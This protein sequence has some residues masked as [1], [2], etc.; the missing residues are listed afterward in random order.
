MCPLSVVGLSAALAVAVRAR[1]AEGSLVSVRGLA[2]VAGVSQP[3][4]ANW[5]AG[6]RGLSLDYLDALRVAAG[7]GWCELAG[8][9]KE[10]GVAGGEL[11]AMPA[12]PRR[13]A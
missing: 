4:V 12:P 3:S 9:R 10:C 7:V 6:R 8:C 13:A 2:K 11:L 1:L 5:L